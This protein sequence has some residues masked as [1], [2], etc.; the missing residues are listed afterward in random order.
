MRIFYFARID[1]AV[2]GADS[3]HVFESC[4]NFAKLGHSVFL[5]L[6]DLGHRPSV[7]GVS[8]K[9]V[10]VLSKKS[11]VTFFSFYFFLF[12][13]FIFYFFKSRPDVIYTRH[14]Q[15]EW[16]TTWTR[17]ILPVKY[18]IEVNGVSTVELAIYSQSRRLIKMT[19]RLEW[20]VFRLPHLI[21]TPHR[22]IRDALCQNYGLNPDRF[23]VVSNGANPDIFRPMDAGECRRRLNLDKDG[24]YLIFVGS[25]KK[26]HGID[27]IVKVFP[28]LLEKIPKIHLLLVGD[29]DQRPSMERFVLEN[30]I[31]S[32]VHFLGKKKFEEI[33]P[34]INAAD[35]CV[36]PYF[37]ELLN[38]TGISPLKI[39]EYMACGKPVISS[40]LGGLETLFHT[41]EIGALVDSKDPEDWVPAIEDLINDEERRR[42]LGANARKALEE[43]FAWPVICEKILVAIGQ[44]R[45]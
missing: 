15:M 12:F 25:F 28:R 38:Q 8:I 27:R 42:H 6:P 3:R 10:P 36:A 23:L 18:V 16:L 43:V 30:K 44:L 11:S 20:M 5:F 39:Y 34:I 9:L 40:P 22:N 21:V 2:D 33:P 32:R 37:D 17:L 7:E 19:Q 35:L 29:G 24:I 26:W 31:E 45:S 41:Y 14:Q 13:Q 4:S 1:S